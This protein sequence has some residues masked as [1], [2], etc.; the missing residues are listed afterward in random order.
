ML[1]RNN[2]S[3]DHT[4]TSYTEITAPTRRVKESKAPRARQAWLVSLVGEDRQPPAASV[5]SPSALALVL[6]AAAA[7]PG[8]TQRSYV[9][10]PGGQ[11]KQ[12]AVGLCGSTCMHGRLFNLDARVD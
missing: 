11:R 4:R 8:A 5:A 10:R 12:K 7:R 3:P 9:V 6:W 2:A 1:R